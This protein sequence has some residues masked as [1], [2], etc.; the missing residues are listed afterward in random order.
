MRF[1]MVICLAVMV[2]HQPASASD[3]DKDADC[4]TS[5][6]KHDF[7]NGAQVVLPAEWTYNS[8]PMPMAG[9][10]NIR[11]KKPGMVIAVTGLPNVNNV[12]FTEETIKALLADKASKLYFPISREKSVD[13]K[14]ISKST[15]VGGYAIFTAN[16]NDK[17]FQVLKNQYY[18]SVAD[19]IISYKNMVFSISLASELAPDKDFNL[20][21]N[22]ISKM[23]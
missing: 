14:S 3:C 8:Y 12:P 23:E 2:V 21:L 17:P 13:Y 5:S 9:A 1:L 7:G 16:L 6:K 22:A 18:S 15:L 20:A 11:I 4:T 10:T 19:I